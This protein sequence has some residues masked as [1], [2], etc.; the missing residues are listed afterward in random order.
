MWTQLPGYRA[1]TDRTEDAATE[2]RNYLGSIPA[3]ASAV[4]RLIARKQDSTESQTSQSA[5]TARG[6]SS[7]GVQQNL[8]SKQQDMAIKL[9]MQALLSTLWSSVASSA[10]AADS[11]VRQP[12]QSTPP[13]WKGSAANYIAKIIMSMPQLLSSMSS[14]V[15]TQLTSLRALEAIMLALDVITEEHSGAEQRHSGQWGTAL[16]TQ[17]RA[18][19]QRCELVI[20]KLIPES[21]AGYELRPACGVE[22]VT[23]VKALLQC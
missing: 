16:G 7:T 4:K 6:H 21:I 10:P 11:V 22:R 23:W 2:L 3:L 20:P 15:R 19:C 9:A 1:G 13:V 5:A 8:T 14:Q 12:D 17:C 18:S